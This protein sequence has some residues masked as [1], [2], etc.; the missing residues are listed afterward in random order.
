MQY[1]WKQFLDSKQLPSVM[2]QN[3]LKELVISS[4]QMYYKDNSDSFVGIRSKFLPDIQKFLQ[5]WDDTMIEDITET[6]LEIEEIIVLF[7]KWC[8]LNNKAISSLNDK[9]VLE[10]ISYFFPNVET[11]RDKFISH[12]RC[13][14]W[15]KH[16]DIQVA[17]NNMKDTIRLNSMNYVRPVSPSGNSHNISIYDAYNFYCKYHSSLNNDIENIISRRMIVSK[18]Y[19]EK[20]IFEHLSEYVIDSKFLAAEW[21]V[22]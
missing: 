16:L 19:F 10:L 6:D 2:F 21:Y 11:E 18:S 9:Q 20:Y 13:T 8:E 15:D 5:F 12:I 17:L 22:L 3:T 4:L 7:R 1:L 14:L